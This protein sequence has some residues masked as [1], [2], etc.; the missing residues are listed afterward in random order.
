MEANEAQWSS[1][2][3]ITISSFVR[4]S[5]KRLFGEGIEEERSLAVGTSS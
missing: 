4:L 5:A 3:R 2:R 1:R